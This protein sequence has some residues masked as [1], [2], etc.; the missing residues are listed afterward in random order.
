MRVE[1]VETIVH[2]RRFFQGVSAATWGTFSVARGETSVRALT[3]RELLA[4]SDAVLDVVTV[5]NRANWTEVFGARRVVTLWHL[6]LKEQFFGAFVAADVATLGGVV[7]D[8]QQWV[9]HEAQLELGARYLLFLRRGALGH[10]WVTGMAQGAFPL[11]VEREDAWRVQ[12][13]AEQAELASR[14]SSAVT[15]LKGRSNEAVRRLISQL[16]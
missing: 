16:S 10:V 15:V 9:P 5:G 11:E 4:A 2:R 12:I 3:P 8:V 6:E 13:S 1:D 7:G 14:S